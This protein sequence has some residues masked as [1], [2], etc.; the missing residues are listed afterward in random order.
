MA[1]LSARNVAGLWRYVLFR[2][3]F[4]HLRVGLFYLD[5]GAFLLVGPN[6]RVNFGKRVRFMRDFSC[7]FQGRVTIGN[8]VYFGRG[9]TLSAHEEIRIGDNCVFAEHVSIHDENHVMR[10]SEPIAARGYVCAPIVIGNNVWV[11]AKATILQGVTIGDNAVIG[12]N[13]VVTRNVPADSVAVGI[14][15]RVVRTLDSEPRTFGE[16]RCGS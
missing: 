2:L 15:A 11:G 7:S 16:R 3:R 6:A 5:R 14:P 4:R 13:A 10:G 9:C 1:R 12:A 8:D